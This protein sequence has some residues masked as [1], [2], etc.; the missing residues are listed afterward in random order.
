M[1]RF[2]AIDL[3]D[4]SLDPVERLLRGSRQDG[5]TLSCNLSKPEYRLLQQLLMASGT[6][7]SRDDLTGHAWDGR[8]VTAGSL[9]NA[10][11]NLRQAF[12][13][14][15]GHKVIR[16]VPSQGY[17][18]EARVLDGLALQPA[19]P[20][21]GP[22]APAME[23]APG[24]T[25]KRPWSRGWVPAL[26]AVALV[27]LGAV[28]W[29]A[30]L[31]AIPSLPQTPHRLTYEY[32]ADIGERRFFTQVS[33]LPASD[34]TERALKAFVDYPPQRGADKHYVYLNRGD[35]DDELSFFLCQN[36]LDAAPPN[37]STYVI[38]RDPHS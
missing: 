37:C 20:A 27:N 16:T 21:E 25:T 24:A 9:S 12:G 13:A 19:I 35:S 26:V 4:C 28:F 5:A 31:R 30:Q 36:S 3:W 8:P 2:V 6:P 22:E 11:F 38:Q 1:I 34:W 29:Y 10:V 18:I 7:V 33:P 15:D 17:R 14:E 32:L 23:Q